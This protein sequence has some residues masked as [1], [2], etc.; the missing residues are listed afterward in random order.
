MAQVFSI[1][2]YASPAWLT[3]GIGRREMGDI[4]RIHFKAIQI[5][6]KDYKQR[7]SRTS[8]SSKNQ[9]TPP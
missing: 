8:I 7:P 2:Y 5:V 9:Q 3:P 6:T 1:I 4:K